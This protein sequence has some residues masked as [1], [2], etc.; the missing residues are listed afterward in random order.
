M[1]CRNRQ[2]AREALDIAA[3]GKVKCYYVTKPL[4]A[5]KEVYEGL[6][7]GK[8]RYTKGVDSIHGILQNEAS[9]TLGYSADMK[10][11]TNKS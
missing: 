1:V 4:A 8:V 3:R 9:N 10:R 6:E 7:Q 5:L 11:E 2:D